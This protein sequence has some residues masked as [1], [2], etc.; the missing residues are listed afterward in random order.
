[1]REIKQPGKHSYVF[2]PYLEPI[3]KVKPGEEVV[4]YTDDAFENKIT[5]ETD[6]PSEILGKYLNPQTGPIYIEGAEPGDTL[7]AH[8]IDIQPTRDWAVSIL[9]PYFG[10]LTATPTTKMLHEPLPEKVWIYELRDG[11]LVNNTQLSF[12]W[13]PFMGTIGTAPDLEAVSALTPADHGGN[14]DV[15]DTKPGNSVYLPVNVP[16]AYF[17]TGDCHAGQG[18]GELCGVAMEISGKV[19]MKFELIKGKSINW[20]RIESPTEIMAV[21]SARPM[22]DAA[23]I[24]YGEL[25]EWMIELGWDQLDAYQAL[26]QIG[27]LYVGNM[28]DTNYSLVAKIE[29]KYAYIDKN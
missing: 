6:V 23:R 25:I 4:I 18:E 15:P 7:I 22:E 19:T 26:S 27:K 20:P 11:M 14:M 10:G 24:A 3:A 12:P 16:G 1:M 5:K 21:G 2:S 29:K 17:Y 28:V 8:I 13:R 9:N